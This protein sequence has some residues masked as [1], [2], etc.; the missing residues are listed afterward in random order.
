MEA[1][2]CEVPVVATDVGAVSEV[3]VDG[4]S[5]YLVRPENPEELAQRINLLLSNEGLRH[6][7][8]ASGRRQTIENFDVNICVERYTKAFESA[9]MFRGGRQR[10]AA[11]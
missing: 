2:A 3:V 7:L 4:E 5:G 10:R 8:G 6:D 9:L 1:L 11:T